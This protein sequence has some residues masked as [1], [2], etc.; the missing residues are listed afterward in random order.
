MGEMT[1]PTAKIVDD[2]LQRIVAAVHPIRVVLFGSTASGRTRPG[3]DID[4]LVIVPDGVHRRRTT[5]KLHRSLAGIGVAK[6][7]VVVTE[8]DV[9]EHGGNPSLVIMPA[10]RDGKEIYRAAG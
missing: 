3:S 8:T 7:I 6:D 2:I 10:L 1:E 4:L 9:V 5:Q